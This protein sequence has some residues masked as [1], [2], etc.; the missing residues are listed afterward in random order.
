MLI[1]SNEKNLDKINQIFDKWDLE[2][3]VIGKTVFS[4]KYEVYYNNKII[5]SDSISNLDSP[6]DYVNIPIKYIKV[7]QKS[8]TKL[9]IHIYGLCMI[10][11]LEIEHL[12]ASDKPGHYAILDIY[13]RLGNN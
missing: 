13:M 5:Y 9:K 12:K 10:L 3:A 2:Y 11:L 6:E 4:S 1:V 8:P 7:N